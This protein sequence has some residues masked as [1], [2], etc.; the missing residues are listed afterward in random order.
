MGDAFDAA[1]VAAFGYGRSQK[2]AALWGTLKTWLRLF[3]TEECYQY[4]VDKLSTYQVSV[5]AM[6]IDAAPS[7]GR[8]GM[9]HRLCLYPYPLIDSSRAT[10]APPW[11]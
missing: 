4:N 2:L 3:D 5:C 9:A 8:Q 11:R 6:V 7:P 1:R 10:R